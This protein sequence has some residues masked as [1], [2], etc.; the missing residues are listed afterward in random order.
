MKVLLINT[1]DRSGGAAVACNRLLQAL[2][3]EGVDAK[4]LAQEQTHPD[5]LVV[6]AGEAG[7][8]SKNAF[9]RFLL[10]R[11]EVYFQEKDK[12]VRFAFSPA[13]I[14]A[15][16]S[17]HPAVLEADILHLHWVQFGFLSIDS[18]KKLIQLGKPI[19]WTLHDM[20]AFTGGCHYSGDCKNYLSHCHTC[21]YL[22]RPG[23]KDLSW[24]I[25]EQKIELFGRGQIHFVTCSQWLAGQAKESALLKNFP[26]TAIPNPINIEKFSSKNKIAARRHTRLPEGKELILFGA[27]NTKDSRKGFTYLKDALQLLKNTFPKTADDVELVIFGKTDPEMLAGLPFPVNNRGQVQSEAELVYLYNACDITVLP[28]LQDNLPNVVM[29]SMACCTPVVAFDTSGLPEMVQ[30]NRNGY[31]A[32]PRSADDLAQGIYQTLYQSSTQLLQA[33][34]RQK[35]IDCYSE[36]KVAG[37]YRQVYKSFL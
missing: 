3:K 37:Q 20:W 2:H 14:G 35:V 13:H 26:V 31:L 32:Q 16:I 11:L 18:L 10:D 7:K 9:G 22:K 6:P 17:R 25:F 4:L 1:F 5:P 33:H 24:K 8:A 12:S 36:S 34:A 15:D 30:H 29:E 21:P 27:M 23:P 28:S 19:V